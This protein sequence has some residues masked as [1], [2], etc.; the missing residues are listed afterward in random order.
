MNSIVPAAFLTGQTAFAFDAPPA[1]DYSVAMTPEV[2]ELLSHNAAVAVGI[3]GGKDSMACAL[4]VKEHLDDVGYTGPRVLVHASLGAIEWPGVIEQCETLARHLGWELLIVRRNGGGLIERWQSRWESSIRR[5]AALEIMKIILPFSTAQWRFCTGEM[6]QQP[7]FSALRKRFP[8]HDILNVTGIRHQESASRSRMPI[9]QPIPQLSTKGRTAVAW[10]AI[11]TWLLPDVF[12]Y[13]RRSELPLHHAYTQYGSSR[14]SCSFCI[15]SSIDDMRAA[16][17]CEANQQAYR[18]IVELEA[19]SS[20]SF[21]RNR[22]LG[23]VAPHLLTSDLRD[24]LERAKEIAKLRDHAE[25]RIPKHLLY[26]KGWPLVMPTA[27][28]AALIAEVRCEIASLLGLEISYRDADSVL[29]RFAE[30]MAQ[31]AAK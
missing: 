25:A 3:S 10:N 30:M 7:I 22:W 26:V 16:A 14:L 29:N 20:F 18:S 2:E 11:A 31:K 5:Y 21:Q 6:K 27:E 1:A 17:S 4:A 28:E 12:E 15:M 19:E 8:Q 9:S 23:D 24:K 13:I